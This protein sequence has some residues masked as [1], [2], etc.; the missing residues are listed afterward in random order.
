M[1]EHLDTATLTPAGQVMVA[2]A[3]GARPH[4][5]VYQCLIIAQQPARQELLGEAARQGG[6]EPI[7][8]P[9]PRVALACLR[10]MSV[11]LALVDLEG[12]RR[13][14]LRGLVQTLTGSPGL[15]VAVCGNGGDASEEIAMRQSGVWLYLPGA[16]N[17]ASIAV[18]CTE[19]RQATERQQRPQ[20]KPGVNQRRGPGPASR[21]SR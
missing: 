5:G 4:V 19:A 12:T 15:L 2:R 11:Q 13:D 17:V 3:N 8:C 6:W 1:M 16:R 20:N 14:S 7:V 9:E 18:L 10:V 21:R